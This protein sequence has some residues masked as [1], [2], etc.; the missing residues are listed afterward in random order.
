[1]IIV[2]GTTSD[3]SNSQTLYLGYDAH[4]RGLVPDRIIEEKLP[5]IDAWCKENGL[6][7]YRFCR[8]EEDGATAWY[9]NIADP[10]DYLAFQFQFYAI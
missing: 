2:E 1:M 3:I 5:A 4:Q 9:I 7:E 6:G 8:C 10:A